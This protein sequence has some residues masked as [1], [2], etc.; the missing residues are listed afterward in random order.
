MIERHGGKKE[1]ER[2]R[3]KK[4]RRVKVLICL[5]RLQQDVIKRV[6]GNAIGNESCFQALSGLSFLFLFL[7]W[8]R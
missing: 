4:E 7:P 8:L 1:R 3:G 5:C 6:E 2:R